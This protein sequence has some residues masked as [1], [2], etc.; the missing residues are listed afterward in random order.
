MWSLA[1]FRV[2]EKE[3][4]IYTLCQRGNLQEIYCLDDQSEKR[5]HIY[6]YI[7][8]DNIKIA[9]K[10]VGWKLWIRFMWLIIGNAFLMQN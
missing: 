10:E 4:E 7:G 2:R 3:T 1:R 9:V 5:K 6:I 8:E